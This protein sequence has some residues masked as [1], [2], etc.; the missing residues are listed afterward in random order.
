MNANA[1]GLPLVL[2]ALL[3]AVPG[4]AAPAQAA[5]SF[6]WPDGARAA[7]SL[8]FDDAR[9]SQLDVGLPVLDRHGVKATFFLVPSPA[10]ERREGWKAA[11]ASGH[12]IGNHSLDHPCTGNFAWSREKALEDFTLERMRRQLVGANERLRAMLGVTPDTFAY[13]CG[14]TFVGRGKRTRSYVPLVAKMFVAGRGWLGEAPNDP[15]RVDLAQVLGRE[16]DG[17][18]FEQVRGLLEEAR[19]AGAWLVLAGH[20]VGASG[21]QTTRVAMLENLLPHLRDPANGY[22]VAPVGAVARYIDARRH[23]TR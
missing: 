23:P 3:L 2:A 12:E 1:I 10:E 8:S 22:W 9:P 21:P 14:E 6:S 19:D 15:T 11:A 4:R 13:P 17:K 5:A 20:D 18:D 16:M 7:V